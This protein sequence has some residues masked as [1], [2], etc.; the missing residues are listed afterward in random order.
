M[1]T[2]FI[3]YTLYTSS[4]FSSFFTNAGARA[5]RCFA[6]LQCKGN[7]LTSVS[8]PRDCCVGSSVGVTYDSSGENEP[9]HICEGEAPLYV[10]VIVF[11]CLSVYVYTYVC[12]YTYAGYVHNV[13]SLVYSTYYVWTYVLIGV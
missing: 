2:D 8:T 10:C 6:R 5:I 3:V 1:C 13:R 9:C 11:L 7:F 4:R 12:I